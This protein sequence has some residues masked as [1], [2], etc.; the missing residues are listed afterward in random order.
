MRSAML[1]LS[2]LAVASTASA[3][4]TIYGI[5]FRMDRFYTTDTG[6]FVGNFTTVGPNSQSIFCIDFDQT[7]TTLWGINFDTS[8]YG[9]FDLSTGVFT[10][11]GLVSGPTG[12]CTGL[13]CTTSGLWYVSEVAT[14]SNLWVGDVTTGA[15]TLVGP[16]TTGLIIDISISATGALYGNNISDDSLYSIDTTTGAGTL[17]GPTGQATNFAQG[18]DFNWADGVLYATLYT[19]GGTGVFAT[20]DLSTGAATVLQSTTPLNAEMEMA[21]KESASLGPIPILAGEDAWQ[22]TPGG[23]TSADFASQP[24]P[25]GFFYPGSDPFVG[26]VC[27]QGEPLET[28]PPLLLGATDTIVRRLT[29]TPPLNMGDSAQV[30]IELVALNLVSCQPLIVTG[31]GQC[32][33]WHLRVCPDGPQPIG[34]ML[35]RRL[36]PDGGT[37][38]TDLPIQARLVFTRESD[39]LQH[40]MPAPPDMLQAQGSVWTYIGGPGGFNPDDQNQDRIQPGVQFLQCGQPGMTLMGQSNF[41]PGNDGCQPGGTG[42]FPCDLTPEQ[43]LWASHGVWPGGDTDQDGHPDCIDNCPTASNPGQEDWDG[44]GEGD[45]CDGLNA[46]RLCFGDGNGAPC[47]CCNYGG[48]EEGCAHSGGQGAKLGVSGTTNPD[49]LNLHATGAKANQFGLFFEGRSLL[50]NGQGFPF[51]DGIRCVGVNVIRIKIVLTDG[52]GDANYGPGSGDPTVS[53]KT[54]AV[55]GD[56]RGYQFWYRDPGGSPCGSSFNLSNAV[57]LVW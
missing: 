11:H 8:E 57:E 36:C 38:S 53:S 12:N 32:Q 26:Q 7:A 49:T 35:I 23:G 1:L 9:T 27:L 41:R 47:P 5:D 29:D 10:A 52:S 51:G 17:I 15:F 21:V 22:T 24:I 33:E 54:G 3:Q 14:G 40:I 55:P 44:D 39:G 18:M 42:G 4:S 56:L 45:V 13:T 28:Q 43:M 19:G 30:P 6:D 48:P 20:L 31:A 37:F 50:N 16:I 25:A 46:R 2:A 34:Q